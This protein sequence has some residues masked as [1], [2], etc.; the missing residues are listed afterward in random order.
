[1]NKHEKMIY[2][3]ESAAELL[4]KEM[5]VTYEKLP[6]NWNRLHVAGIIKHLDR[7]HYSL[8]PDDLKLCYT[9]IVD[10]P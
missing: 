7:I 4:Q 5:P 1:M 10:N 3:R 6:E 2:F 8:W 9:D